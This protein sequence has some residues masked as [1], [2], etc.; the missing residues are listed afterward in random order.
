M[1]SI[2]PHGPAGRPVQAAGLGHVETPQ[3][4]SLVASPARLE[5]VKAHGDIALA[6]GWPK[7]VG[8]DLADRWMK[9]AALDPAGALWAADRGRFSDPVEPLNASG[10]TTL[11]VSTTLRR[12]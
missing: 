7:A 4:A 6:A 9:Q 5:K 11:G 2:G 3:T 10:S 12:A 8:N 1:P